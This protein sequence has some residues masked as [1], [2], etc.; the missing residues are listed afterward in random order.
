M[1]EAQGYTQLH[2]QA[3]GARLQ[4]LEKTE[5]PRLK[6]EL[7]SFH[8]SFV[9]IYQLLLKKG[10][11]QEDPYKQETKVG[12]LEIPPTGAFSDAKKTDEL[13]I[14]LSNYDNQLDF[15]VNFYQLSCEFLTIDRI[16]RIAGLVK[17]IDW[18]SFTNAS[19]GHNTKVLSELLGSVKSSL[20]QISI[21]IISE[22][23]S[24]LQ[25]ATGSVMGIL[26]ELADYQREYIKGQIREKICSELNFAPDAGLSKKTE[27]LTQIKKK[28]SAALG[29]PFSTELT[30]ELINEDYTP[31][32]RALQEKILKSLA[33]PDTKLKVQKK[34]VSFKAVLIDG[35]YMLGSVSQT[36]ADIVIK[37]DE[38]NAIMESVKKGVWEK[39]RKVFQ[40]MLHKAPEPVI[41]RLQYLDPVKGITTKED[42]NYYALKTDLEKKIRTTAVFHARQ[43][44]ARF[45]AMEEDQILAL[46][47][48]GVKDIQNTHKI[49]SALDEYFKAG[50]PPEVRE[51]IKGIKPELAAI[52][53]AIVNANQKRYEYSAQKEEAE[54]LKKLGIDA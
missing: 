43:G 25:K 46:L 1:P 7:R 40:E 21:T 54:Q 17:Y 32:G 10:I 2:A 31:Q 50:A 41:Y 15:L 34:Q 4:W 39:I 42:I 37:I 19:Q 11:L 14:R 18:V 23:L 45:N 30:E 9:N 28:Y 47:N 12:E 8:S 5:L 51:K 24:T 6:E 26:K 36:I 53:N 3:L 44:A 33:L 29:I 22:S 35:L 38:N 52:K 27:I 48:R 49:L 20:D 16:K 13:S